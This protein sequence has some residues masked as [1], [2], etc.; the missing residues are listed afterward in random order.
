MS[1]WNHQDVADYYERQRGM[2]P[3]T[4]NS[5]VLNS[6]SRGEAPSDRLASAPSR[7]RTYVHFEKDSKTG[8]VAVCFTVPGP[9]CPKPR[10]TA[11]DKW[12]NPPRPCVARYR[13]WADKARECAGELPA[14]P[15]HLDVKFFL[16]IPP[17]W[18]A[19]KREAHRGQPHQVKPD[20]DN[21]E[22]AVADALFR[23]DEHIWKG[24]QEKRWEDENGP[25]V[26]ITIY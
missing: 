21:L 17:S 23:H 15:G 10:Q 1:N 20:K 9:P 16:P 8:E 11:R 2:K 25:R 19:K 4:R 18:T 14:K 7:Y 26:E 24:Q 5:T 12:L 3:S 22:K 13:A 6:P